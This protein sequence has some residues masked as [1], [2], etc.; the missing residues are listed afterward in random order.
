[1]W[2]PY[3]GGSLSEPFQSLALFSPPTPLFSGFRGSPETSSLNSCA[4]PEDRPDLYQQQ[5]PGAGVCDVVL[6][7]PP[8]RKTCHRHRV[9]KVRSGA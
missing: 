7:Q 1:M 6:A 4:T 9:A 2:T 3:F 5:D 8:L